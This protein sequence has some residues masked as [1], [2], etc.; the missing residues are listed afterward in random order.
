MRNNQDAIILK[1]QQNIRQ[2]KCF[3]GIEALQTSVISCFIYKKSVD[4]QFAKFSR[5]AFRNI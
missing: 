5:V 1:L 4:L 2:Q 3:K